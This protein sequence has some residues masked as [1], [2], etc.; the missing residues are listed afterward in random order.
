MPKLSSIVTDQGQITLPKKIRSMLTLQTGDSIQFVVE[1]TGRV[2]LQKPHIAGSSA[3]CGKRFLKLG[4]K[5]LSMEEIRTAMT[6]ARALKHR[7]SSNA[8]A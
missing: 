7:P 6:E 3:G 4:Q 1:E 8:K 5:K 2:L